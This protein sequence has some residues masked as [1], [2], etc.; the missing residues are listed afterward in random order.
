MFPD[1]NYHLRTRIAKIYFQGTIKLTNLMFE[2][3]INDI[4]MQFT[5]PRLLLCM[6]N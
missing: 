6:I 2:N 4:M 5:S 1:Y 3:L